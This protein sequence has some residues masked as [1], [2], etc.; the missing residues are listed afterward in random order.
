[1]QG[2]WVSKRGSS[3]VG[4]SV[5]TLGILHISNVNIVNVYM[6]V[7]IYVYMGVCVCV[8]I[9]FLFFNQYFS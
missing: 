1:M 6:C 2:L 8:C 3:H 4:A 7:C 9:V 5:T